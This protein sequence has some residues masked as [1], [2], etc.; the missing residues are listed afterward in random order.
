MV[1]DDDRAIVYLVK[2]I[3]EREQFEVME[4]YDG[5]EAYNMLTATDSG[6]PLPDVIIL[7]TLMPGMDGYTLQSKLRETD[8]L[9]KIPVIVLTGKDNPMGDLF[10]LSDNV[11]AFLEKPFEP[12]NLVKITKDA[13]ASRNRERALN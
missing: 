3:M 4:A 9:N 11:F 10:A 1:V 13:L 5:L 8:G 6:R 7:D 12:R 2:V